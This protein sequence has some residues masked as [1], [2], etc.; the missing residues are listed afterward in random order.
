[1]AKEYSKNILEMDK[2]SLLT[3]VLALGYVVSRFLEIPSRMVKLMLFGSPLHFWVDSQTIMIL[4]VTASVISGTDMMIRSHVLFKGDHRNIR[5]YY[6]CI[7]PMLSVV[8]IGIVLDSWAME[9]EWL[10]GLLC[11]MAFLVLVLITEYRAVEFPVLNS[12]R[13]R[14]LA[15]YYPIG[16]LWLFWLV[17]IQVRAAIS[18]IAAMVV[19]ALLS[20]RLLYGYGLS[21][22]RAGWNGFVIGLIIGEL[23]WVLGYL[24]L[25]PIVVA[26]SLLLV[27]HI[28]V[29]LIRN[30]SEMVS[31]L[32]SIVEYSLVTIL[33]I[34]VL[35]M[36]QIV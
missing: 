34:S 28:S 5:P 3:S 9:S 25:P 31:N 27:L 8:I 17:N 30:L 29:G 22:S 21:A 13:I 12:V 36:L 4:L 19:I 32:H 18:S 11:G 24:A 14:L 15:L 20:F 10:A 35:V 33:V 7:G 16:L 23:V 26:I 2:L 1:M 6:H